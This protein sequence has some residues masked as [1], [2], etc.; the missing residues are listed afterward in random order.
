MDRLKRCSI[1]L[2]VLVLFLL[3]ACGDTGGEENNTVKNTPVPTRTEER[4][5]QKW[6]KEVTL[7]NGTVVWTMT[8]EL[9]FSHLSEK[10]IN[11]LNEK[12]LADGYDCTLT[13]RYIPQKAYREKVLELA[14]TGEMDITCLGVFYANEAKE[15]AYVI[16]QGIFEELSE[17]LET[18]Q[19]QL[20]KQEF[21]EDVWKSVETDG[22]IYSVPNQNS[23]EGTGYYVFN[24]DYF[25]EDEV[26]AFSGD[27]TE[28]EQMLKGK[29]LPEDVIPLLTVDSLTAWEG[30][31]GYQ[32][33]WGV[34][35][36][37]ETGKVYNPYEV[38]EYEQ[39]LYWLHSMKEKKVAYMPKTL[40]ER[41]KIAENGKFA[42]WIAAICDQTFENVRD[43][44][45]LV[46][47]PYAFRNSV[48][49]TNAVSKNA[50][51]KEQALQLLTLLYTNAEYAN[52]LIY[53][54]ENVDY[55]VADG[56]V[57]GTGDNASRMS[58]QKF[59]TGLY[60][61]LLPHQEDY[62]PVN[63]IETKNDIYNS[64]ARL[65]NSI[66]GFKPD[67]SGFDEKMMNL[68]VLVEWKYR[69]WADDNFEELFAETKKLYEEAGG[70]KVVEELNRQIEEWKK[71][72]GKE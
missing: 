1:L 39:L 2:A 56:Y 58:A 17:Y 18:E 72:Y 20:L 69:L 33:R 49:M 67:F 36:N 37:L 22:G 21:P 13:V 27:Y 53:G 25:S 11:L 7:G 59:M 57:K 35:I 47:M 32:S 48:S 61:R 43:N 5:L 64:P 42:V 41:Q 50:E 60:N 51:H 52:L 63:R 29:K 3:T 8:N 38:P 10:N 15:A 4:E 24:K 65:E 46:H 71:K 19:G 28:L 9:G 6:E 66:L 31:L 40:E 16:R 30:T 54:E 45:F 44:S 12:L 23:V 26:N 68:D 55:Q 62:Y 34:F 14:Q 70:N